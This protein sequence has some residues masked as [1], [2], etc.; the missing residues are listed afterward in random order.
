MDANLI[1]GL[2]LMGAVVAFALTT[3]VLFFL[4]PLASRLHLLDHPQGRKDHAHPTP[5]TGGIAILVGCLVA[6]FGIQASTSSLH[7]FSIAAILVVAVGVY[8]DLRDL[9]W[10]WRILAQSAAA[11]IIIYWGGVRI[12]Q[13]GPA[14]GLGEFSLG[15]LAVPLTVFATVGIINA[16][17]MIDGADGLAGLLGLAALAMFAAAAV[18]AGNVAL[19]NRLSVLCGALAGFLAWNV[20]LPW[21]PRAKVFLG[22]AGSALLGL[23]IAWVAFR[24]TQNPG[25]PV[26]P[27]LALWLLPIPVMDC[28]VLIVRRLQEGRSPFSAARDHIHHFMQDAGFG[29]TRAAVWLTLFTL[30]C[31]MLVAQAMRLDIPHP[32]LLAAFLLLCLGWYLLTRDRERAVAFF[33]RLR[34]APVA[35]TRPVP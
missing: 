1:R 24:L 20:R 16:M 7:A 2:D 3:L 25:H 22:N 4:Q 32:A 12:A 9:R 14:L 17:N 35:A 8:D 19:A 33:R 26:N 23:V 5:V 30:A 11:L 6:F 21:R 34:R 28:L 15:W 10:Y 18:Y 29:P 13:I 27:V 31:G